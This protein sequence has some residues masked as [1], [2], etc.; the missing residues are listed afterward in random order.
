MNKIVISA[1]IFY[2]KNYIL[3]HIVIAA[4]VLFPIDVTVID[5]TVGAIVILDVRELVSRM[6]DV[7]VKEALRHSDIPLR[8]D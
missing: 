8:L 2:H 1:G 4:I 5:I 3:Y 7:R 6:V